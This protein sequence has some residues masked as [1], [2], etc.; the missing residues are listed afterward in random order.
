MSASLQRP[1][2]ICH[3][4]ASMD[5]RIDGPYMFDGAAVPSRRVYSELQGAFGADAV[6]Y[7]AMTTQGFVGFDVPHTVAGAEVPEGD[8]VA[9]HSENSYYVSID[10]EGAIAW[11]DATYRRSGRQD[12]HVIELLCEN[13]PVE[14]RA[15]LRGHGI[16]YIVA[17]ELELDLELALCKLHK[18]FGIER[19]LVCGG[20]KT[21]AAFLAAGVLDE[22]SVVLAP[23]ASGEAGVATIF[24]EASFAPGGSY[25]LH[26][27]HVER[28]DG[29]GVHLV[30]RA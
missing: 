7:G 18:L 4:F 28:V 17:G 2:V 1:Y 10:P 3:V 13:T 11:G 23:V 24:D 14:Y 21:D 20:G 16:S 29:D 22:L 6:A 5:G 12:A 8:Y 25:P 27:E 9:P 19:V 30:Y 26:L 15:F